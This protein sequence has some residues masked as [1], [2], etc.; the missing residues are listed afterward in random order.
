L[1]ERRQRK[2]RGRR[3]QVKCNAIQW[4]G[5]QREERLRAENLGSHTEAFSKYFKFKIKKKHLF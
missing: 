1:V 4:C 3:V 2:G 5:W